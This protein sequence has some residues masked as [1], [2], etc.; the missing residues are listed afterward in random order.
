MIGCRLNK[1]SE[2]LRCLNMVKECEL[3]GE[4]EKSYEEKSC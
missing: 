4:S 1:V 2:M 3:E